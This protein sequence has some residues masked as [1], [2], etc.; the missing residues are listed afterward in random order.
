MD[1]LINKKKLLNDIRLIEG[2]NFIS[3]ENA[4]LTEYKIK[5]ENQSSLSIKILS[6]LGGFLATLT[7]LGFLFITGI[8]K[9]ELVASI[10]GSCLIIV[11]IL[12]NKGTNKLIIDTFSISAY[13]VG[14]ILFSAGLLG[15]SVDENLITLLVIGIALISLFITQ[16]Y[17]LSFIAMLA[18]NCS[19]LMLIL[20]NKIPNLIHVYIVINTLVLTYIFL[21]EPKLISSNIK[22]SKLYNP[23]RISFIISLLIGL[24][25]IIKRFFITVPQNYVWSS[26][27]VIIAAIFYVLFLILKTI[28]INSFQNKVGIYVLSALILIPIVFSPSILGTILIILLSFLV[29]YKTG[30]IIGVVSFI[31]FISQYYYDLSFTLLTK[32]IILFSSGIVFLL[33]YLLTIKKLNFNEKV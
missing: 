16:N 20:I 28:E 19:F 21:N 13:V 24:V 10:F 15:M 18:I 25:I 7:F 17:I 1:K 23:S 5:E 14:L 26:S 33:L 29:N 22:I 3:D 6:I 31:Y 8:L 2:E 30:F 12:I 11:A 4:I 27:I 9:S 32:S